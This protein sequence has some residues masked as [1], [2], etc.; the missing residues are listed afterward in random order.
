MYPSSTNTS[1]NST[2]G[3]G[4]THGINTSTEERALNLLGSGVSLEATASACGVSVSRI[5]QLMA[6]EEFAAK[7]SALRYEALQKHN[8]HDAAL[9]NIEE[10]LTDKFK[11]SIPL[12]MRPMEILKGLQVIN[13]AKR[14]GVERV[15]AVEAKAQVVNIVLPSVIVNNFTKSAITTNVHNQVVSITNEN[16]EDVMDLTTIQSGALLNQHKVAIENK[17][18]E[19]RADETTIKQR[20]NNLLNHTT[21]RTANEYNQSAESITPTKTKRVDRSPENI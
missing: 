7:V 20:V 11:E 8:V 3:V 18:Q 6:S 5:S 14:R 16:G 21:E 19:A 13:A 4:K 17:E 2:A 9:D 12:M 15:E 1:Q 10:L